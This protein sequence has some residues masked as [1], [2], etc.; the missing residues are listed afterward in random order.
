MTTAAT[1]TPEQAA[2]RLAEYVRPGFAEEWRR[3]GRVVGYRQLGRALRVVEVP[4]PMVARAPSSNGHKARPRAGKVP[5]GQYPDCPVAYLEGKNGRRRDRQHQCS[6]ACM[7]ERSEITDWCNATPYPTKAEP[8]RQKPPEICACGAAMASHY[9]IALNESGFVSGFRKE[10]CYCEVDDWWKGPP[11]VVAGVR[12]PRGE[13]K[14]PG[15]PS[16][17]GYGA[18]WLH[19]NG[20][21]RGAAVEARLRAHTFRG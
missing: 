20:Y 8:S 7:W 1:M 19:C 6:A 17:V 11:A 18:Q 15:L 5:A 16:E 9:K 12:A 13:S 3:L 4:E 10:P 21:S 14:G 2:G